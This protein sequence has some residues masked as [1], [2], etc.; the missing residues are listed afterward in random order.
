MESSVHLRPA[1]VGD[2]HFI[3]EDWVG[4]DMSRHKANVALDPKYLMVAVDENDEPVG[5][6]LLYFS[7]NVRCV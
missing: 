3:Y 1:K 4:F 5:M 2:E 7:T 6:H